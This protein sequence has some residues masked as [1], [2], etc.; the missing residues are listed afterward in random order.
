MKKL[1][2]PLLALCLLLCLASCKDD[3][4]PFTPSTASE[5]SETS[6]FRF[7]GE[8]TIDDLPVIDIGSLG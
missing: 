8:A 4:E 2:F 7:G 5:K 6:G 1:L 3:A